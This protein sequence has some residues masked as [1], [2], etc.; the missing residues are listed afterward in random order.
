M[1]PEDGDSNTVNES[2]SWVRAHSAPFRALTK[3]VPAQRHSSSLAPSLQ[4]HTPTHIHTHPPTDQ[5]PHNMLLTA[6]LTYFTGSVKSYW[7]SHVTGFLHA[8]T[9]SSIH[10]SGTGI[11]TQSLSLKSSPPSRG[12]SLQ[13]CLV[14]V[15]GATHGHGR[16]SHTIS[17]RADRG[18]NEGHSPSKWDG[19]RSH[20]SKHLVPGLPSLVASTSQWEHQA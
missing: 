5:W 10:C 12:N 20:C 16:A 17:I 13:T 15:E 6:S 11:K 8:H 19:S 14:T 7:V 2:Y 4:T 1:C 18:G 3:A 9:H